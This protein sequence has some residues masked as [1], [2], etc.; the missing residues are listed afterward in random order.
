MALKKNLN[1]DNTMNMLSGLSEQVKET[2]QKQREPEKKPFKKPR[3]DYYNLDMIVRETI[4][5][6]KGHPIITEGI[7]V[8]YKDYIQAMAA[9]EGLS[10]TKYIHKLIDEDMEANKD[11][12]KKISKLKKK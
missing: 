4:P 2:K 5:G 3:G 9:G 10:I 11:K 6:P 7:K 1:L 8:N 12:Y